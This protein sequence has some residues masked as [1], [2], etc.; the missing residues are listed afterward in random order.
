MQ[1]VCSTFCQERNAKRMFKMSPSASK[2]N[3]KGNPNS[4]YY[5]Q[6]VDVG[7]I[8]AYPHFFITIA[9][10]ICTLRSDLKGTL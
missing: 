9:P 3:K 8:L 5:I 4:N 10:L 6:N 1:K 2:M 7:G